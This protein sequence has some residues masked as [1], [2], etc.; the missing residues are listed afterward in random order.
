MADLMKPLGENVLK[1]ATH[2]FGSG[3][4]CSPPSVLLGIFVAEGDIV[5]SVYS[6]IDRKMA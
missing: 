1:E 2:E 3:E 4:G 6:K 5:E